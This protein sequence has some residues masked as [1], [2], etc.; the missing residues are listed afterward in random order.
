M[1]PSK[2][3][4]RS[5][6][7]VTA[8]LTVVFTWAGRRFGMPSD[9]VDALVTI[10]L[11]A[12]VAF[13]AQDGAEQAGAHKTLLDSAEAAAASG[14]EKLALALLKASG[15]KVSDKPPEEPVAPVNLTV[16]K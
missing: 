4:S 16:V 5:R 14:D 3:L 2:P 8:A 9:V 6:T 11:G 12:I 7:V 1:T 15:A 10:A 13:R